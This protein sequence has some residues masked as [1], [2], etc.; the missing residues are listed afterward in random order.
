MFPCYQAVGTPS[1]L[2]VRAARHPAPP[3]PR[4]LLYPPQGTAGYPTHGPMVQQG[5]LYRQVQDSRV[6]NLQR[7]YYLQQ[8]VSPPNQQLLR[9]AGQPNPPLTANQRVALQHALVQRQRTALHNNQPLMAYQ[10]M[11]NQ[12]LTPSPIFSRRLSPSPMLNQRVSP[13]P[14]LNQRL[15]PSPLL[16]QRVST[17]PMLNQSPSPVIN[18]RFSPSP[19][20]SQR[21]TPSPL[22]NQRL[23]PSPMQYPQ[24]PRRQPHPLHH[25]PRQPVSQGE[26]HRPP[27]RLPPASA[28]APQPSRPEPPPSRPSLRQISTDDWPELLRPVATCPSGQLLLNIILARPIPY[29]S[30]PS[31]SSRPSTSSQQSRP[32]DPQTSS[33]ANSPSRSAGPRPVSP[34]ICPRL[35]ERLTTSLARLADQQPNSPRLAEQVRMCQ[36][37]VDQETN[38]DSEEDEEEM[39]ARTWDEMDLSAMNPLDLAYIPARTYYRYPI[40][41]LIRV[42]ALPPSLALEVHFRR[43]L[44]RQLRMLMPIDL[45]RGLDL[46]ETYNLPMTRRAALRL[47]RFLRQTPFRPPPNSQA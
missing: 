39:P 23:T 46:L 6:T 29:P 30:G 26:A 38:S 17:H 28:P 45:R 31:R 27:S 5:L 25:L 12:R 35:A 3:P 8:V 14:M 22:L 21:M 16:S 1:Y 9:T 10:P 18:Q 4:T 37:V 7:T 13:S 34:T 36:T 40:T 15:S 33:R 20:L 43:T 32:P 2:P 47:A 19:V 42:P 11:L 44:F 24:Y 41:D